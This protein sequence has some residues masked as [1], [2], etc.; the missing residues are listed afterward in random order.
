MEAVTMSDQK[1]KVVTTQVITK[2]EVIRSLAEEF[3]MTVETVGSIYDS[4][5]NRIR[6][7]L[8]SANEDT[9]IE[10]HLFDG[11]KLESKFLP[12]KEKLNNLTGKT[13]MVDKRIKAKASLSRRYLENLNRKNRKKK[14]T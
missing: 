6:L 3:N 14:I 1:D 10:I 2:R 9:N 13:Q 12:S 4:L 5:E 7:M 8:G 11:V